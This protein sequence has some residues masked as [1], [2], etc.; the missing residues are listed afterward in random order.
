MKRES[1]ITINKLLNLLLL[2]SGAIVLSGCATPGRPFQTVQPM[3]D[4]GVLYVYTAPHVST[5]SEVL[6]DD[7]A[8]GCLKGREC[9]AFQCRPG[10]LTVGTG[11][12]SDINQVRLNIEAKRQYFV[13]VSC[14]YLVGREVLSLGL[15]PDKFEIKPK[16]VSAQNALEQLR[17]C[18]IIEPSKGLASERWGK[19]TPGTDLRQLGPIYVDTGKHAATTAP[20]LT[21]GLIGRGYQVKMGPASDVPP[22]TRCVV[23]IREKWFWD[24]G[25]YLL[26][27]KVEFLNP[28]TKSVYASGYVERAA[29]QGRRGPKVMAT[30]VLNA[31]FNHGM[32]PGVES[33]PWTNK[34]LQQP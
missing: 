22:N 13:E 29:V 16:Q 34:K 28:Q 24:L 12:E 14:R 7:S 5:S 4:K 23:K 2:V 11:W 9:L 6:I 33:A 1:K 32:P 15:M 21:A 8:V 17:R 30:E 3:A 31:I 27:L 19:V 10:P 25:K 20:F 26:S 18:Q